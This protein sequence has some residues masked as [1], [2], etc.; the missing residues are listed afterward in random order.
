MPSPALKCV[1]MRQENTQTA[2]LGG[3]E[4][5]GTVDDVGKVKQERMKGADRAKVTA[6]K[7][8]TKISN[9]DKNKVDE[10]R[11]SE[12][13]CTVAVDTSPSVSFRQLDNLAAGK[14][15]GTGEGGVLVNQYRMTDADAEKVDA[16]EK[17][18][19]PD[20]SDSFKIDTPMIDVKRG[21]GKP[22]AVAIKL[23]R[24]EYLIQHS[25]HDAQ[26]DGEGADTGTFD[27]KKRQKMRQQ[28]TEFQNAKQSL[29]T[30]R[31]VL[32]NTDGLKR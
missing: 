2:S 12:K 32:G 28:K 9:A 3:W 17:S 6:K 8:A 16:N 24:H 18:D 27:A 22:C 4:E 13:P 25:L 7:E 14:D 30:E 23:Y 20:T 21:I 10:K 5:G 31:L 15:G 11:E 26:S 29:M 19:N 1:S